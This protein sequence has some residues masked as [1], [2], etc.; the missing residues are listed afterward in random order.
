MTASPAAETSY[1]LIYQTSTDFNTGP[2]L[3]ASTT[4]LANLTNLGTAIVTLDKNA[5]VNG[6][7]TLSNGTLNGSTRTLTLRGNFVS[8]SIGNFVSGPVVFD[9]ITTISGATT[10]TF[11]AV[12]ANSG[13]TL[14]LALQRRPPLR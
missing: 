8:N 4:A 12:T 7:L 11:G 14:N 13:A 3:P 9:G 5:T 1:N 6:V 10:A 2:E